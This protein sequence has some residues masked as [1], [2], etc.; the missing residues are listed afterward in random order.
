MGNHSNLKLVKNE[1]GKNL[2]IHRKENLGRE[3]HSKTQFNRRA[4]GCNHAIRK[5]PFDEALEG[6]TARR[7]P[8]EW[9]GIP[10]RNPEES[11][12]KLSRDVEDWVDGHTISNTNAARRRPG[13]W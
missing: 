6:F 5:S 4:L 12:L 10:V 8:F 7:C 3:F 2:K 1:Q 13:G 11:F 9:G